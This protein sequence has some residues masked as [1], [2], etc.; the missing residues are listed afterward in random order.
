MTLPPQPEKKPARPK[1]KAIQRD[2]GEFTDL[3]I[4][5]LIGADHPARLIWKIVADLDLSAFE[6][7]VA[8][9]EREV[10]RSRWS[11][12]L[13]TS[14]LTYGYTLGTG[15]ARELERLMASDPGLRWLGAME[16]VN[17]HTLSDFRVQKME[18]LQGILTQVLALLANE[19]LVDF[20]CLLQD[21]TKMRAQASPGSFHRQKTVSEHLAEAEACVTELDRRAAEENERSRTQ[22]EAAQERAARERLARMQAAKAELDRRM[23]ATTPARRADVRVSESEPEAGK[24][25]HAH[26]GFLP[27]YNLQLVTEGLNGFVAGWT[28]TTSTNDLHE[29]PAALAVAQTGT[30]TPAKKVIADAGY[31]SR[32]NV[33]TLA[34]DGIALVAP[35]LSDEKRQA[36]ST[37]RAGL[38]P[39]FAAGK[40][41]PAA[42]DQTLTC[43]AGATLIFL[44]T[45]THHDLPVRRYQAD[46]QV[47]ATCA[48]KADCSPGR[49]ARLVERII[50]SE[51]MQ[52]YF[53][54]M[55][56]PVTQ[57]L[58][59]KR[60]QFA[61]FP[62]MKIKAVW[63]LDR[64]RLRGVEK[65]TKEAFW[66]VLAFTM[67]RWLL[68][69]RQAAS[70]A[71]A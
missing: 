44:N 52:T 69:R 9:F 49:E 14:I 68:L 54:R 24:M 47:C 41:V 20:A 53:R 57:A 50:E 61:E 4:D 31:A 38:K 65:V 36:G 32:E 16:V 37:A 58:Y 45:G 46:A 55:E 21:G 23:A 7:D 27:S 33:E 56:D 15:S 66:M 11:P 62:N 13:L 2:R 59:K 5:H 67:D 18:N 48:H 60:S 63:G 6:K 17:H 12:Q 35:W 25:K 43:P 39:A 51:V 19:N 3:Y 64:F 29:L 22:K 8:S 26:G 1:Y 34:K 30:Q 28:V 42:D 10:G 70:A 71:A 40:F